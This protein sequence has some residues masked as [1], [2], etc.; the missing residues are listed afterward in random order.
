ML[1][2]KDLPKIDRLVKFVYR[3]K[4]HIKNEVEKQEPTTLVEAY[5][6]AD[7]LEGVEGTKKKFQ[8]TFQLKKKENGAMQKEA[9]L[10]IILIA[11]YQIQT[12]K[13][14]LELHNFQTLRSF[15]EHKVILN[16][17]QRVIKRVQNVLHVMNMDIFLMIVHILQG[18]Q[19]NQKKRLT[20]WTR[21]LFL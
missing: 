10:P 16:V 6:M 18:F 9:M 14:N 12:S 3:L 21:N 5:R 1:S 15:L 19:T 20:Q 8:I 13:R 2:L 11:K 4:P 17:M 7:R